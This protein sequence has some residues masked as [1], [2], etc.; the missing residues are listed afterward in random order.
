MTFA[1]CA[2]RSGRLSFRGDLEGRPLVVVNARAPELAVPEVRQAL[3]AKALFEELHRERQPDSASLGPVAR[4]LYREGAALL[5][6]R[7]LVPRALE[8]QLLGL[9]TATLSRLRARET[10]A[11]KE[12]LA[13]LDTSR[14]SETARFF[15]PAVKDPLLPPGSGLYLADRLFQRLSAEL[16]STIRPLNLSPAEFLTAARKHLALIAGGKQ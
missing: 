3:L 16:G 1:F 4:R 15:D 6:V 12:L 7:Q 14:P 2:L 9:D 13:A 11:A 10:L 8:G 5:A